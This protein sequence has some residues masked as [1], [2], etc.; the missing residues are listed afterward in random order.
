[1]KPTATAKRA[2]YDKAMKGEAESVH[3]LNFQYSQL[4]KAIN[5]FPS[6]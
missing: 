2:Q 3:L 6:P 1:M 5:A 4:K